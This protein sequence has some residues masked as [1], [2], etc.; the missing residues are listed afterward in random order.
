MTKNEELKPCPFCGNKAMIKEIDT[1]KVK[2]SEFDKHYQVKCTKCPAKLNEMWFW[3]P[4][5]AIRAWN[6]RV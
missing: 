2:I 1:S 6:R 4:E 3:K 5:P